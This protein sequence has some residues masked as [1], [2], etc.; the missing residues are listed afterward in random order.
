[1]S[2]FRARER[3][4]CGT[5]S[6]R[7]CTGCSNGAPLVGG[8]CG[9]AVRYDAPVGLGDRARIGSDASAGVCVGPKAGCVAYGGW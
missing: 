4:F 7:V 6:A 3:E 9:E 2:G 1:M 5:S 8:Y